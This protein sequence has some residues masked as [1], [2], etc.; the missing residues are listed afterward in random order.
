MSSQG[1]L[2]KL[3]ELLVEQG[4]DPAHLAATDTAATQDGHEIVDLARADP[5]HAGLLNRR[6]Q[7]AI[8]APPRLKQGREEAARA[9]LG[10]LQLQTSRAGVE[11]P[12]PVAVAVRGSGRRPFVRSGADLSR[13]LGFD[14]PRH[15]VFEDASQHVR[16]ISGSRP[17]MN[18]SRRARPPVGF[19]ELA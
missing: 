1:T 17:P 2:T 4:T 15:G 6:E 10:D 14:Q 9:Q 12:L 5:E 7:G 13:R 11:Y 3:G 16:G 19:E 18:D 8:N